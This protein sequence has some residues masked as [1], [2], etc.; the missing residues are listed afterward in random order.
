MGCVCVWRGKACWQCGKEKPAGLLEH[1]GRMPASSYATGTLWPVP[2]SVCVFLIVCAQL[3]STT[4]NLRLVLVCVHTVYVCSPN[5]CET[6]CMRSC[7]AFGVCFQLSCAPA[8]CVCVCVRVYVCGRRADEDGAC[9]IFDVICSLTSV[10][11]FSIQSSS[12]FHYAF[13]S[14]AL[15]CESYISIS[16]SVLDIKCIICGKKMEEQ[17]NPNLQIICTRMTHP[18]HDSTQIQQQYRL[19]VY[20]IYLYLD[21]RLTLWQMQTPASITGDA[22]WPAVQDC[23]IG[24]SFSTNRHSTIHS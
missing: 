15:W 19:V 14:T 24:C 9:L 3:N 7:P 13:P 23:N 17:S 2:V 6:A 1:S 11:I 12:V 10:I 21:Y 4:E 22:W 5:V 8:Y 18:P 16:L 20:N